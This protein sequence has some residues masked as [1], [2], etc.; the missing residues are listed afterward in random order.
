MVVIL[1]VATFLGNEEP[2]QISDLIGQSSADKGGGWGI[3]HMAVLHG[4]SA[5]KQVCRHFLF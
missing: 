2:E 1:L 3:S 4:E 5:D